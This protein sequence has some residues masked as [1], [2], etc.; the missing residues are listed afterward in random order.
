MK[1]RCRA[2]LWLGLTVAAVPAL[3]QINVPSDGSDGVF[4]PTANVEVDLSRA[5]TGPWTQPGN[6]DGVYDATQWAIV[7]KYASVNIPA[8]VTVR[9]KNHPKNPPV[10]WLVQ[11]NV[12]IAGTVD[13]KGDAQIGPPNGLARRAGP[14]GF[15][16]AIHGSGFPSGQG[17]GPGGARFS[18][19]IA[20]YALPRNGSVYGNPQIIP[21]IGGSSGAWF[22]GSI[23][24]APGA[25]LIASGQT[26]SLSGLLD[27]RSHAYASGG[28]VRMIADS[29]TG[30]G[31][32]QAT[33]QFNSPGR[34][35]IESRTNSLTGVISP[36]PSVK[37]LAGPDDVQIWPNST[38]P[39]L[40][41]VQVDSVDTPDDPLASLELSRADVGIT[42][43][44]TTKVRLES[45]NVPA[46]WSVEVR[47]VKTSTGQGE[48]ALAT[49]IQRT[50]N[51]AIWEANITF[52]AGFTMLQARAF[53]PGTSGRPAPASAPSARLSDIPAALRVAQAMTTGVRR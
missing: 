38:H 7:F 51:A 6:G 40:T 1:V 33:S 30:G 21:L 44:G 47:A 8:G 45:L 16:G 36:V 27:A 31:L 17:F 37:V 43:V 35:R 53:A 24:G 46:N 12:T 19:G 11:G 32:I 9:F 4:A 13:L 28:A 23:D 26:V 39:R 34:I 25:L 49:E 5:V 29:L 14:G 15:R 20:G 41:I 2:W 18:D 42:R 52:P 22:N 3:A 10:V 50:G 48:V